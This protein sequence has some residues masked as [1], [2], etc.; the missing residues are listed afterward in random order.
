MTPYF[1][2]ILQVR[3]DAIWYVMSCRSDVYR[4]QSLCEKQEA[5]VKGAYKGS[6][7]KDGITCLRSRN[8]E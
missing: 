6:Q 7:A 4:S 1:E 2:P 5:E 8:L 3:G